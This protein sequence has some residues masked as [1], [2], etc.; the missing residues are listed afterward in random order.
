[1]A[2]V[3]MHGMEGYSLTPNWLGR[4]GEDVEMGNGLRQGDPASL[5]SLMLPSDRRAPHGNGKGTE[6]LC[7]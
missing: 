4:E 6:C 3:L 1:M 5:Q 7:Q 2:V